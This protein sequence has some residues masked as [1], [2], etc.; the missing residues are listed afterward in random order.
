MSLV[1][2]LGTNH[3]DLKGPER[4]R[5]FLGFVRPTAI[6]LEASEELIKQRLSD[7]KYIKAEMEKQKQFDKMMEGLYFATGR[8][9]PKDNDQMVL[10]FLATQGYEI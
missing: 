1:Y 9:A 2:L 7:R 6:G 4:L 8:E 10:D 5:K 3:W